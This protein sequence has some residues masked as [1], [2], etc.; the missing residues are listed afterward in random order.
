VRS[1][2]E[3]VDVLTAKEDSL[4]LLRSILEEE[5]R[6]IVELRADELNKM[7]CRKEEV[8]ETVRE[9][10]E[11]LRETLTRSFRELN[12]AGEINLS[13]VIEKLNGLEKDK[14]LSLQDR[15]VSVAHNIENL[16]S[17]NGGLLESSLR[18]VNGSM[19]FFKQVLS[20]SDTYGNAGRMMETP[21]AT[22][23]I[24]REI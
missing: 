11:R 7:T 3:L 1:F 18:L 16:L 8:A 24:C 17:V 19:N 21:A 10:N 2:L 13:P 15:L 22:R 12:L 5:Q 6:C 14:L 4:R 20:K 9:L 23:I